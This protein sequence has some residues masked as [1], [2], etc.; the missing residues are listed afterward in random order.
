MTEC[1]FPLSYVEQGWHVDLQDP[2]II[3]EFVVESTEHLAGIEH[4]LLTIEAAG[5]DIDVELVNTVFRGVHSIKGAAG[6]LG[7]TTINEL[8]HSLEN[9]LNLMRERQLVP[10]SHIVDVMLKSADQLRHL[11]QDVAGSNSV[12]VSDLVSMLQSI[13]SGNAEPSVPAAPLESAPGQDSTLLPK[14]GTSASAALAA[15]DALIAAAAAGELPMEAAARLQLGVGNPPARDGGTSPQ[16]EAALKSHPEAAPK[17]Q[18]EAAAAK[19]SGESNIRVSVESLDRLMNLAGELVLG[20][21]QLLQSVSHGEMVGLEAVAAKINQV[22]SE[23]QD[24]IMKTR[25]QPIGNVFSRFTRVVRD[26]SAKLNKQCQLVIEG[27]EVEVD[28]T[29]IEAI[30]DPLTHLVRN[31]VDHGIE[32]ASKRQAN[33]KPPQGTLLLR[34]FHQSGKVCIE[35]KDDGGGIDAARVKNKAVEKGMLTAEQAAEMHDQ[36]AYR[37]ILMPGFSTAEQVSDVSGR[38]VGMDVVRTNIEKLGG[39]VEID[40]TLGRGTR[41]QVTLPLTLAIIPS[42]IVN[43]CRNRFAIP[44]VNIVELVRVRSNELRSRIGKVK[45]AEVLRLRGSL[46]PL[47][48]LSD[49]LALTAAADRK[50]VDADAKQEAPAISIIVVESGQIRYGLIVDG[51]YDSEEI[52]V[53][54]LGKHLKDSRCLSGATILGDGRVAL[55]LDVAGISQHVALG[56]TCDRGSDDGSEDTRDAAGD[57]QSLL[58]FSNHPSEQF[59]IAMGMIARIERVTADQIKQLGNQLLLQYRDDALPLIRLQ[60]H[61]HAQPHAEG[62]RMFVVVFEVNGKEVGLIAP[63]LKDVRRITAVVDEVTMRQPGV[64]GS[65]VIDGHATRLID[66]HE[67]VA[68]KYPDWVPAATTSTSRDDDEQSC[69]ILLAEDSKFFR[70]QVKKHL[71]SCGYTILEAEDGQYAWERLLADP[72]AVDLVV[73]DVQ[74]PRLDGFAL[75]ERIKQDP[76]TSHLPVIALTSLAGD[77]DVRRGHQCGVDEYQIKMDREQLLLAIQRLHRASLVH[78][79]H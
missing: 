66:V 10:T 2:E 3:E 45:D 34:A 53:K 75:C 12:N 49:A 62:E 79:S 69:R 31:S 46:L 33:G 29:I 30:A 16:P 38:G 24:A 22:T 25:M 59:A 39:T 13:A 5:A 11:V 73:T 50:P 55:I 37:L 42:L 35:I 27:K 15:A 63:A 44:Q 74:M 26:L 72:S 28:K 41:I 57:T 47:I 68:M 56:A 76:R 58:V 52:V 40:S 64:M 67:L 71:E 20:R 14:A 54:P 18:P 65:L 48:R 32:P 61:I 19:S 1:A 78:T 77:E 36:D 6:F 9:V 8:A 23:M 70:N 4:Q 7:L 51:L 17:S 60:D 43:C 21:N